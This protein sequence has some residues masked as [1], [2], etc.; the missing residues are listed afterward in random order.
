MVWKVSSVW[1]EV[2]FVNAGIGNT[3][4]LSNMGLVFL[5]LN[6]CGHGLENFLYLKLYNTMIVIDFS[7]CQHW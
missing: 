7:I 5:Y 4:L 2:L 1:N 6:N 3:P